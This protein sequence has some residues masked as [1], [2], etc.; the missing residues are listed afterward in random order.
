[1]NKRVCDLLQ[2]AYPLALPYIKDEDR[3]FRFAKEIVD[4]NP[5]LRITLI[6]SKELDIHHEDPMWLNTWLKIYQ[7]YRQQD[8]PSLHHLNTVS[9]P[10]D[11]HAATRR[12]DQGRILIEEL[13]NSRRAQ[14]S[15][16]AFHPR[17]TKNFGTISQ[18]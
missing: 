15:K 7:H 1:M 13:N 11:Y 5:S 14:Q 10:V 12:F 2:K 3:L 16:R 17:V 9:R 6:L 4:A 18:G 8:H